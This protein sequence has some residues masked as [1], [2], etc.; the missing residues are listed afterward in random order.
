MSEDLEPLPP[1]EAVNLYLDHR[2]PDV[3]NKTLQNQR[4][5]LNSFLEWCDEF[6]I[7]NLNDLSG[8]DLHRY[9]TWRSD[10]VNAVTLRGELATL[11]VFLEFCASIDG[12]EDGMRERVLLPDVDRDQEAKDVEL[13]DERARR[14]LGHLEKFAY[15]SRDHVIMAVLWHTGIRLGTLRALDLRDWDSDEPCLDIRHR[16][17]TGT[18]LKNATAANR[19]IAVGPGYAEVIED[20]IDHNRHAVV[21]DHG[22]K[23]LLTS[24]Q[25]RFSSTAIRNTIYRLTRP[26]MVRECPHDRDPETCEAMEPDQASRCPTSRSPHA[27]RRGSITH[28][29]REEIPQRVVEERSNVSGEVLEQHYDER[30]EREKMRLRSDF[31]QNLR[32]NE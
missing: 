21:D 3:S 27:I 22:R 26:C 17:D 7:G 19:S 28:Q 31:I 25:G 16:P 8:R 13:T 20:Y 14:I 5:R 24:T 6:G 2:E 10:Q 9:R 18:P 11:R 30:S 1:A 15:A 23:P 4:Y 32:D 29:L 12:V